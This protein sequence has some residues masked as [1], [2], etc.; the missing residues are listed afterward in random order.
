MQ[1]IIIICLVVFAVI[2]LYQNSQYLSGMSGR[3]S[4]GASDAG[5][6]LKGILHL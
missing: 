5:S 1:R 3:A 2:Y 4:S 6:F